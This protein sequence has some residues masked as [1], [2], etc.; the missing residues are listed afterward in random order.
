MTLLALVGASASVLPGE[1]VAATTP[2]TLLAYHG[3]PSVVNG[4]TTVA[5]AAAEFGRYDIVVFGGG[6]ESPSHPDHAGTKAVIA[7]PSMAGTAVFG[8]VNL[9]VT[10]PGGNLTLAQLKT[11][12]DQWK[13]IGADGIQ[14][15]AF[16]YDWGV[17]RERQN[18]VVDYVH[19]LG[20]PV[21]ANGWFVDHAFSAA[22]DTTYNQNGLPTHL[23]ASDYYMYESFWVR[24]G[25][26]PNPTDQE[27]WTYDYW[28]NKTQLLATYQASLHF[29][30]LSVT[31][32]GPG[33]VYSQQLFNAAW[34]KAAEY[35]HVATG[36][37]QYLFSADDNLA[38]YRPRPAASG[39]VQAI[40][41]TLPATIVGTPGADR[42]SGTEHPDVIAGL[43]GPDVIYGLG[44]D[45]VICGGAG[46]DTIRGGAGKDRLLGGAGADSLFGDEAN[47][48]LLGQGGNDVLQG[49][50][51]ANDVARGGALTD[52]CDAEREFAC[53][54]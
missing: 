5:E 17:T 25:R 36:W 19:S 48:R 26:E 42:L 45:D 13:A 18:A 9:G 46:Q 51:G 10:N 4:A 40:C 35:G 15:D 44:G 7:H 37:G 47:D 2:G 3:W 20:M 6:L 28:L 24:L 16:G 23:G 33:D 11:R 34:T 39:E 32:N 38:P 22:V 27:G 49:G 8:Y 54:G 29:S 50:P 14:L 41:A 52:T 21:I 31:T 30:I 12:I 53:E 1:A 43:D